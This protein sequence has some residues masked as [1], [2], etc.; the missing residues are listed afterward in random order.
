MSAV[1]ESYY[2]TTP[3]FYVNDRPHLGTAYSVVVA[4]AVA[5][6]HRL[7]GE[8]V[9][10]LT[11]TD[12]HGL[13]LARAAAE[14]N[15]TPKAWVDQASQ[16]FVDAWGVLGISYDQF[17][18]TSEPRHHETVQAFLQTIYDNGY[19]YKGNY[20]GWYCVACENYYTEAEL[21]PGERCPVHETPVEW[22]V[23]ENY[24][25]AL[26]RFTE[27]LVAF[28]DTHPDAVLPESRRNEALGVINS[29]L[30]DVSI[31]RTSFDWGVRVPWD[32]DHIVYV[33]FDA[34]INYLTAIGFDTDPDRAK[35][36]WPVVHHLIGKDILRFHSVWWPAMCLAAGI[37]PPAQVIAHGWLMVG[38]E[39]MSK[40]RTNQIDPVELAAD[41]G[42]DPLRYQL[43]RD[44]TVGA[45]GDF[46]YEGFL[47][48][49]NADLANNLGNL[50]QRV[51]TVVGQKCGGIG[52]APQPLAPD[53]ILANAAVDAVGRAR[54]AWAR[55]QPGEALEAALFLVRETNAALELAEPWKLEPGPAVDAVLGDALEAL[56]IVT[57][58]VAPAIPTSAQA[59]WTRLGLSGAPDEPG[60]AAPDGDLA[61]GGYPGGLTVTR[62]DPLFP[63]RRAEE[64]EARA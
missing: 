27:A 9:F 10:F 19:I 1:A 22:L 49:Y 38:G 41:M 43:L 53:H 33:W 32:Q 62:G 44:V 18:R 35:R 64:P 36:Y 59:I 29:G 61:W 31:S 4:D 58:L 7:L 21:L 14:H 16:Y 37:E 45:D 28:Y 51:S 42:V 6:W 20:A 17:I 47:V 46:S 13:K 34:L 12:E 54:D 57:V 3:I 24:F 23:E 60:R 40:S 56:R 5:R 8:D 26:S 2:L 63:R 39:K 15:M 52:P 30:E 48:R 55:F 50:L 25:F 11:G